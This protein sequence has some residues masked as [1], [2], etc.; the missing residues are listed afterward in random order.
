MNIKKMVA[1]I[2]SACNT[3]ETEKAEL[4]SRVQ[5]IDDRLTAYHMA[6]DSLNLAGPA[7]EHKPVAKDTKPVEVPVR[8]GRRTVLTLN[9]KSQTLA[10]WAKDL[11]MSPDGI[12]YRLNHG[13]SVADALSK[14]KMCYKVP[15]KPQ[16][17]FAY[18][19]LGK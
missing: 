14:D 13:W 18:D 8:I 9:E 5:V 17:V 2:M 19:K 7:D 15:Q 12:M 11:R 16:K 3:L 1:E 10:Q 4:L 6:I